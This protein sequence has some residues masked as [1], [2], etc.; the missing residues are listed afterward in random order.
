MTGIKGM[1]FRRSGVQVFRCSGVQVFRSGKGG[2][3]FDFVDP[4][5][6]KTRTPEYLITL[7]RF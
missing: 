1:V 4:E 6:L 5:H 2:L 7:P 3:V